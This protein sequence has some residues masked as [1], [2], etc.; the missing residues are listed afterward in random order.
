MTGDIVAGKNNGGEKY[1]G[2]SENCYAT[3]YHVRTPKIDLA[4]FIMA[5]RNENMVKFPKNRQI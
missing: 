4:G 3:S 2:L 5:G 1:G